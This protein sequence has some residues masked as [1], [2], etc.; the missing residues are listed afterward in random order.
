M[1]MKTLVIVMI[2]AMLLVVTVGSALAAPAPGGPPDWNQP[3]DNIWN[4][5]WQS[6]GQYGWG[7]YVSNI[8][9]NP[10]RPPGP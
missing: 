5:H 2:V 10:H 4:A 1:K 3:H 9:G 8:Q 6:N 7:Y